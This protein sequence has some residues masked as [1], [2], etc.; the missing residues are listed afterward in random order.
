MWQPASPLL[1]GNYETL[2]SIVE[3]G[4]DGPICRIEICQFFVGL[5]EPFATFFRQPVTKNRA[6][7]VVGLVLQASSQQAVTV[8]PHGLAVLIEPGNARRIWARAFFKSAR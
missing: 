2:R 3:H 5:V 6:K 8:E 4:R 1:V 7:K